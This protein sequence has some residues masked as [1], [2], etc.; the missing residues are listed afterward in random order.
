MRERFTHTEAHTTDRPEGRVGELVFER[1]L[2]RCSQGSLQ[3]ALPAHVLLA[4]HMV[5][6]VHMFLPADMLRCFK[7]T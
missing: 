2:R 4:G 1:S 3:N 7:P 5:L 6:A